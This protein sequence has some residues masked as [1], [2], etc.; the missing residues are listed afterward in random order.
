MTRI[1]SAAAAIFA[2]TLSST[3][4]AHP[5]SDIK[6]AEFRGVISRSG[7]EQINFDKS[8]VDRAVWQANADRSMTSYDYSTFLAFARCVARFDPQAASE[9]MRTPI[10]TQAGRDR[11]VRL[12]GV[13]RACLIQPSKVHPLLLRAAFA[14]AAMDDGKVRMVL[15]TPIGVPAVAKGYR[16]ASVSQCQINRAPGLVD[17]LFAAQ[18]GTDAERMAAERLYAETG[19][20]GTATLGGLSPTAAR[21]SLIDVRYRMAARGE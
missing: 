4:A 11:L 20:C 2:A 8:F 7:Q 5:A 21:L 13:N 3:V 6:E 9:V 14:E 12:A 10:G 1:L 18:P 17:A 15:A 19:G 16:L